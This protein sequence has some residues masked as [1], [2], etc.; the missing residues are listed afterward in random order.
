MRKQVLDFLKELA[1][2]W[3]EQ[4][5]PS[6]GAALAYYAMFSIAPLL[7]IAIA[8]AGLFFG[9]DA[10]RGAVFAQLA[11]LM[12]QESA[13]AIQ[14]M[15]AHVSEP[16]TGV[17][18]TVLGAAGLLLGASGVFAELQAAMDVIWRVPSQAKPNGI[19][20]FLH[21]RL[22]TFG[23][24]LGLGFLV[25]VSLLLS[26][27][28]AALGKW[29]GGYLE[30]WQYL[31]QALDLAVNLIVLTGAFGAIFKFMPSRPVPWR[32]VW[33]GAA[34][35]AVLFTIG[36]FLIGLYLGKS[37]VASS[38][39]AFG[40]AVIVMVWVYYSAQIFY[41]GAEFGWVYAH[42]FG[43]RREKAPGAAPATA[44]R[45]EAPVARPVA[46][47]IAIRPGRKSYPRLSY[48]AAFLAGALLGALRS[49][50]GQH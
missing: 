7:F 24:V 37:S 32:D 25:V 22:L 29:W 1:A 19:W 36:K 48:P 16:K 35:T 31:A 28:L 8:I 39:G 42:R 30:G 44:A 26:A 4:R 21:T 46:A 12:G 47:P 43:S 9:A 33:V 15:L 23:M 5:V 10:V 20:G 41:L 3:S 17:I 40:S 13:K 27:A 34:V 14:E 49:V 50:R 45:L 18:G 2:S 6:M 11:D 38:F